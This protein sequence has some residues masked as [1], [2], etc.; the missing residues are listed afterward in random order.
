M[1]GVRVH[2]LHSTPH[3]LSQ[4]IQVGLTC[5]FRPSSY[6]FV[7]VLKSTDPRKGFPYILASHICNHAALLQ[8]DRKGK[9]VVERKIENELLIFSITLR[10]TRST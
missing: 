8:C 9:W 3:E 5:A 6:L 7:H 4:K 10:V 2:P 1:V